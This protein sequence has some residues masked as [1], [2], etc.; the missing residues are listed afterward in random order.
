MITP[1]LEGRAKSADYRMIE[2]F[3]IENF[4]C[5]NKLRLD[6]LQRLNVIV[7]DNAGGKT[8][9]LE[10]LRIARA[11]VPAVI[12]WLNSLR[13]LP[14]YP[15]PLTQESFD[16]IW[17]TYFPSLDKKT[18]IQ[19][20]YWDTRKKASSV[21]IQYD[22]KSATLIM[23][24]QGRPLIPIS[25]IIFK[26]TE[27]KVVQTHRA[28]VNQQNQPVFDPP[29]QSIDLTAYFGTT[30]PMSQQDNARWF[31]AL[32]QRN[33]EAELIQALKDEYDFVEDILILSPGGLS[34]GLY[35]R[36]KGTDGKL[37]LNVISD[38]VNKFFTYALA[39][40]TFRDEI[41]L[42]D[43]IDAG[44]YYKRLPHLWSHLFQLADRFK[45]QLF[46]STH[47]FECLQALLPV[48]EAN[49]NAVCLIRLE[50]DKTG[51]RIAKQFWGS[52]LKAALQSQ[53]EIR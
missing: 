43:E 8:S 5:F 38:G 31:T 20:R 40:Y 1:A 39:M 29:A 12:P 18:V 48:L 30:S 7:G 19:L 23:D 28:Y 9:L 41:V 24:A 15:S 44:I 36:I 17:E 52:D 13:G 35:A 45:T 25:P 50:A 4:R 22:L 33:Q 37:P 51:N 2:A 47:S 53:G 11:G 34:A 6:K 10:A 42:I 16:A 46:A 3:E 21:S 49:L 14:F 26:R 32:S 27:G